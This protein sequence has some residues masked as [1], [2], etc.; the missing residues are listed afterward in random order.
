MIPAGSYFCIHCGAYTKEAYYRNST[1]NYIVKL[2]RSRLFLRN[3]KYQVRVFNLRNT[4]D[5]RIML[6]EE[7]KDIALVKEAVGDPIAPG[8]PNAITVET[9]GSEER[10]T[11]TRCCAHCFKSALYDDGGANTFIVFVGGDR[12]VGKTEWLNAISSADVIDMLNRAGLPYD[13]LLGQRHS[14][15]NNTDQTAL[16]AIGSSNTIH[17]CKKGQPDKIVATVILLDASGEHYRNLKNNT[18]KIYNY[19]TGGRIY[20]R[21]D[22]LIFV[23]SPSQREEEAFEIYPHMC[24]LAPYIRKIPVANVETHLDVILKQPQMIPKVYDEGNTGKYPV[25]NDTTFDKNHSKDFAL[26]KMF[27]RWK[28]ENM[29]GPRLNPV[30]HNVEGNK[31]V[32]YFQVQNGY[33]TRT[34]TFNHSSNLNI[35]DP[36]IWLL[37]KMGLFPLKEVPKKGKR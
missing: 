37:F 12:H 7:R 29:A 31:K 34:G 18:G 6:G 30:V 4:S 2:T 24:R 9:T 17:I 20:A 8:L 21:L 27:A 32:H 13:L 25:F 36:L 3:P 16:D 5:D 35:L 10:V 33:Q 11:L 26:S 1:V 15:E 23:G 22:G 19:L 14:I 28:V